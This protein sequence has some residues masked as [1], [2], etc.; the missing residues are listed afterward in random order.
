MKI[1]N[2]IFCKYRYELLVSIII[3]CI[4]TIITSRIALDGNQYDGSFISEWLYV[5]LPMFISKSI[6]ICP[7][8]IS[9]ILLVSG[10]VYIT[11]WTYYNGFINYIIVII[12]ISISILIYF[13]SIYK[14][15]INKQNFTIIYE[16][17]L[18]NKIYI[19]VPLIHIIA[20]LIPSI[21]RLVMYY[22]Y[23]IN[24]YVYHMGICIFVSLEILS[25]TFISFYI[26]NKIINTTKIYL[27]TIYLFIFVI[28][29]ILISYFVT[30][31]RVL[32]YTRKIYFS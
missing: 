25:K 30:I 19:I 3:S 5:F 22:P 8:N 16:K 13:F 21:L 9:V 12:I 10:I 32:L 17:G 24:K 23:S 20:F 1:I 2:D 15:N 18:S 7:K 6:M 28:F 29:F 26:Y 31:F 14:K 27:K 11:T 4:C